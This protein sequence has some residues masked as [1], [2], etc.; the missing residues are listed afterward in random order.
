M[1]IDGYSLDKQNFKSLKKLRSQKILTAI[2]WERE[3]GVAFSSSTP[4]IPGIQL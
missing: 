4:W 1:N 2:V 3:G